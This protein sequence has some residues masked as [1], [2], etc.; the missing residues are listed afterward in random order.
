MRG[1]TGTRNTPQPVGARGAN[2]DVMS[3]FDDYTVYDEGNGWICSHPITW[4]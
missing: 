3:D 1:G 4:S 2:L